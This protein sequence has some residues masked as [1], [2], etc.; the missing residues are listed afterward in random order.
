MAQ[1]I[2]SYSGDVNCEFK[3]IKQIV[4]TLSF[5]IIASNP[6]SSPL[7]KS[8][9]ITI[10]LN[11]GNSGKSLY[12]LGYTNGT[13]TTNPLGHFETNSMEYRIRGGSLGNQQI[14][15]LA[16]KELYPVP[17]M[18]YNTVFNDVQMMTSDDSGG[19]C[20]QNNDASKKVY[21]LNTA[22]SNNQFGVLSFGYWTPGPIQDI[23]YSD[24]SSVANL[25]KIEAGTF[26]TCGI[27]QD[28][29]ALCW[30]NTLPSS[31][32]PTAIDYTGCG[33]SS[34]VTPRG[35]ACNLVDESN[36]YI[37]NVVDISVGASQNGCLIRNE[38]SIGQVYC[39][40]IGFDNPATITQSVKSM[41]SLNTKSAAKVSVGD[42][43][44]CVAY[45]DNTIKCMGSNSYGRIG[46]NQTDGAYKPATD[47]VFENSSQQSIGIKPHTLQT[48]PY[49]A[50]AIDL[51]D[52]LQCWG[53][54]DRGILTKP[55]QYPTTSTYKYKPTIILE[56]QDIQSYTL[57]SA[58]LCTVN[59]LSEV[60]CVGDNTY[61]NLGNP[62][63][64]IDYNTT[65]VFNN[66]NY[67]SE[68][69]IR[70]I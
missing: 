4:G 65:S 19:I 1:P 68:S 8:D 12:A 49:M 7:A 11:I 9:N 63:T 31:V 23:T 42:N 33:F 25:Q 50:C 5:E 53:Y 40:G 3:F 51:E 58:S 26:Q 69:E 64:L 57:G 15:H 52:K 22:N 28:G 38:N 21:C 6:N 55:A 70:P 56:S 66:T 14:S 16:D 67:I 59:N 35:K 13:I 39:W 47:L 45:T 41:A 24:N 44:V 18:Y 60:R 34:S 43:Y 46:I 20:W 27:E 37:N 54:S 48:K 61:G 29:K 62:R 32:A 36:N 10:N 17:M 30:G 2:G